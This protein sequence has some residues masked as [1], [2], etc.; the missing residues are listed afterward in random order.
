[1]YPLLGARMRGGLSNGY[2]NAESDEVK[3]IVPMFSAGLAREEAIAG[4]TSTRRPNRASRKHCI[5]V[6][7]VKQQP[8]LKNLSFL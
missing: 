4:H 3:S 8:F 2:H 5:S 6:R 1:M 7:E